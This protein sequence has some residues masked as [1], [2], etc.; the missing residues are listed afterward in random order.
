MCYELSNN[1]RV[2]TEDP[3]PAEGSIDLTFSLDSR[4]LLSV[5][6]PYEFQIID[7]THRARMLLGLYHTKLPKE[8]IRKIIIMDSVPL[9]CLGNI[10]YLTSRTDAVCVTNARGKEEAQSIIYKLNEI[11]YNG[12][13]INCKQFG[14]WNV[15]QSNELQTME[16]NLC[17]FQLEKVILHAPLHVSLE[18]A[19]LSE[20]L[21]TLQ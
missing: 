19:S 10:L 5:E 7:A 20:E 6:A 12:F 9:T 14:E 21:F 4:G 8:S 2:E 18:I 1:L 17:D 16:F 15:I 11:I 13:P 3:S